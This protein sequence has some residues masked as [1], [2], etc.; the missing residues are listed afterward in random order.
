MYDNGLEWGI[1]D[2]YFE[3]KAKETK[4][5][6]QMLEELIKQDK[7]YEFLK[8]YIDDLQKEKTWHESK[9][10]EYFRQIG[11]LQCKRDK[12]RAISERLQTRL[13]FELR[14]GKKLSV[15]EAKKEV[16][17]LIA[18]VGTVHYLDED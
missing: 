10:T 5:K 11:P 12:Y 1:A 17:D 6:D 9:A 15:E 13:K 14:T 16:E 7:K 3:R 18:R 2:E 8:K 4:L